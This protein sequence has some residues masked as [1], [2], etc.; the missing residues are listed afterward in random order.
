M[1]IKQ[2]DKWK[3]RVGF[4]CDTRQE[5]DEIAQTVPRRLPNHRRIAYER[6]E[7]GHWIPDS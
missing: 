3:A 2:A 7:A 4:I 5:A 6:A 1:A